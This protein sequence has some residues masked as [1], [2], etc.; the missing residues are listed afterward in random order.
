MADVLEAAGLSI[1]P[2]T[3]LRADVFLVLAFLAAVLFAVVVLAV[4]MIHL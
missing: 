4:V 2:V 3:E 1:F